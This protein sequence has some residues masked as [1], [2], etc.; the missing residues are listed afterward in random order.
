MPERDDLGRVL[1]RYCGEPIDTDRAGENDRYGELAAG[2]HAACIR[3]ARVAPKL[4][5]DEYR[6]AV[7]DSL[8]EIAK[9]LTLLAGVVS[10]A[11]EGGSIGRDPALR[12]RAPEGIEVKK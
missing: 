8:A 1:C 3:L 7:V 10:P 5:E 2:A 4:T 11:I 6:R 9:A 12:V